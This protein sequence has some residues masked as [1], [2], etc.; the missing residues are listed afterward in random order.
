MTAE[1][2]AERNAGRRGI[3][4]VQ[5]LERDNKPASFE[6]L[7]GYRVVYQVDVTLQVSHD[8]IWD[9]QDIL[10]LASGLFQDL[11]EQPALPVR[12]ARG[13]PLTSHLLGH[14]P[15]EGSQQVG[16]GLTVADHLLPSYRRRSR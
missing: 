3:E 13:L 6:D 9:V 5:V 15:G 1:A 16:S 11:A 7:T 12:I 14:N 4:S 2:E 8:A 10:I